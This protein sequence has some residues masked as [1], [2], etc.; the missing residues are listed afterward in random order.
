[1]L[2]AGYVTTILVPVVEILLLFLFFYFVLNFL[3]GTRA[4]GILKGMA[5][6]FLFVLV[7]VMRFTEQFELARIRYMMDRWFLPILVVALLIIFQPE[8]RRALVRIGQNPL[9]TRIFRGERTMIDEVVKAAVRLSKNRVGALIAIEREVR[10]DAFIE[11]GVKL[12]ALVSSEL[13]EAIF[14]P[15]SA[16][17]DGA[18][19]VRQGKIAAAGCLF[20]LSDNPRVA[21]PLGTR[22]RAGIGITEES[23]VVTVIVSEE[24]GK[25]SLGVKGQLQRELDRERLHKLLTELCGGQRGEPSLELQ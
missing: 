25:I 4:A 6:V 23:D 11:S 24:T 22:H 1:M 12:D 14:Y 8:L 19:I 15:G 17:H 13:I 21:A 9:L 20:P 5:L 16:L 2:A 18:I 3:R 7:V 10:L